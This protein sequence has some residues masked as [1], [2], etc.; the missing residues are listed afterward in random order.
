LC[1]LHF[2]R[3]MAPIEGGKPISG[4]SLANIYCRVPRTQ[5]LSVLYKNRI[6][7]TAS[8]FSFFWSISHSDQTLGP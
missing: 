7:M 1:C 5:F 6:I 3:K 4:P 8:L 2:F